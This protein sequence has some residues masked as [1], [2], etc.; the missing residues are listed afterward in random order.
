MVVRSAGRTSRRAPGSCPSPSL[1]I[2]TA[3][4]SR[5]R[6]VRHRRGGGD[7]RTRRHWHEH[8]IDDET[9]VIVRASPGGSARSTPRR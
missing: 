2:T 3:G 9:R 1:P 7:T 4:P 8:H 6:R 5:S